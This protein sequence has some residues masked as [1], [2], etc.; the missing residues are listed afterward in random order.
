MAGSGRADHAAHS[1]ERAITLGHPSYVW[2]HGQERRLALIR[3]YVALEGKAILD[4]GCGLG[5][6]V[7]AFRR[8]S[9]DVLG[10]DIDADKLLQARANLPNLAAATAEA[11]PF[12]TGAL[13]VVL[14]H[15]VIEH[16]TDDRLAVA[17]AVRIL[18]PGGRLVI[19]APNRLYPFETHGAYWGGRYHLGNIPL[20]G[21]LPDR[22]RRRL[23]PHVRAYTRRGIR[24]LLSGLPVRVVAHT[25]IY[26][27]YD[28]IAGRRPVLGRV[29]RGVTYL[30]E[31]T[32]LRAFGLSHL[33]VVEKTDREILPHEPGRTRASERP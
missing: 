17:E 5:M 11:L 27:G 26:P 20:V 21:Y 12:P 29:L 24:Q 16:V 1:Q 4:V 9:Q 2:G 18:E 6:Y 32:P 3:R 22:W 25:Q 33:L 30:L 8:F 14:S 23:A 10:V 31:N 7:Q 28:K 15:E 19:F 13:G